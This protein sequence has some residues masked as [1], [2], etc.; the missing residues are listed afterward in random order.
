MSQPK[1]GGLAAKVYSM[2]DLLAMV[3]DGERMFIHVSQFAA[4][5]VETEL[6]GAPFCIKTNVVGDQ[7]TLERWDVGGDGWGDGAGGS[8]SETFLH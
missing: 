4:F 8:E 6:L 1:D 3:E 7:V 5:L 2:K